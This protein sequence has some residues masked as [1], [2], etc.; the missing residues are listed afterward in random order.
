[1]ELS[2][3]GPFQKDKNGASYVFNYRFSTVGLLTQLGIDFRGEEIDFQDF[4]F[5]LS[6][7]TKKG[8]FKVFAIGGLSN[9]VFTAPLDE[10][11]RE[12]EKDNTNID[13][14][15]DMGL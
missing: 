12:E 5:N 9:N 3:E 6:F 10:T 8:I 14:S 4:A 11:E 15:G 13:F 7:P 2:S 1:M